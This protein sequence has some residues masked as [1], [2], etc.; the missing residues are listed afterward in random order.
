ML[1]MNQMWIGS[2]LYG[3]AKVGGA[4][5]FVCEGVAQVGTV[6]RQQYTEAVDQL[7]L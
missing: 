2:K 3:A 5:C 7:W 1:L 4:Y 6:S